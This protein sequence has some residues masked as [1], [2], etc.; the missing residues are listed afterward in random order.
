LELLGA[1]GNSILNA[2]RSCPGTLCPTQPDYLYLT[3][4]GGSA[5]FDLVWTT[6]VSGQACSQSTSALVTPPNAYDHLT[7]PLDITVCGQPPIV[8]IGTVQYA[9]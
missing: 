8:G 3:A 9:R 6:P 5:F 7:L 4:Q 2:T 1:A